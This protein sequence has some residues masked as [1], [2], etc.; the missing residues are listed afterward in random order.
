MLGH[1]LYLA[2]LAALALATSAQGLG[3]LA[4][5]VLVIGTIGAW[6]YSWAALNFAR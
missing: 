6:R 4:P 1:A 5:V 3:A 2:A